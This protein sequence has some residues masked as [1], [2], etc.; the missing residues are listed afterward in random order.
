[1]RA[2]FGA[3]Y[4]PPFNATSVPPA[5]ASLSQKAPN[6]APAAA[7]APIVSSL[8]IGLTDPVYRYPLPAAAK[9][10]DVLKVEQVTDREYASSCTPRDSIC[11]LLYSFD[12]V[13]F[14]SL[15]L[16][17]AVADMVSFST[18]EPATSR[19]AMFAAA[20]ELPDTLL[21]CPLC[22]STTCPSIYCTCSRC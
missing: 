6:G 2:V 8:L 12:P 11:V 14:I 15:C 5:I 20:F 10:T 17:V 1:M 3:D 9:P 7:A 13:V 21:S 16:T 19:L 18:A 22:Y 4:Q